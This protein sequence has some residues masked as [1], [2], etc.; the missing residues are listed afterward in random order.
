M[1]TAPKTKKR[2]T[3]PAEEVDD[4]EPEA[5]AEDDEVEVRDLGVYDRATGAA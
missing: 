1:R 2:K 4:E 5:E 3:E